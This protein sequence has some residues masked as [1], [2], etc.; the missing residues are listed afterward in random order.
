M[1]TGLFYTHSGIRYLVLLL[2]LV[3]IVRSLIGFTGKKPFEKLDDKLS[4]FLLI[5]THIQFLAGL[6]LYFVSPFVQFNAQTMSD[7]VTR[8]WTVEHIFGMLIAVVLITV[9]R[10][11]SKRMTDPVAKHKRL[12]IFNAIA[13]LIIIVI[14]LH[15]GVPLFGSRM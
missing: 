11:T 4:L 1:Y 3:V 8:Y 12:F 15:G 13:L 7:K 5:F 6:I 10:S 9:A 2:L 14:V